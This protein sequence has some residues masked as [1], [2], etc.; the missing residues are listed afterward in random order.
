M[1]QTMENTSRVMRMV[2]RIRHCKLQLHSLLL[3][4]GIKLSVA[5]LFYE[6]FKFTHLCEH[7][8]EKAFSKTVLIDLTGRCLLH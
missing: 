6:E 2:A 8:S 3:V 4:C 1:F 7:L 5:D